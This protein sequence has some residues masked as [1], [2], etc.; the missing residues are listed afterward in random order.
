MRWFIATVKCM[1]ILTS[2]ALYFVIVF[3][4][5]FALGPIRVIWVEPWLGKTIAAL[6][7]APFLLL[8]MIASALWIPKKTKL[9]KD[10]M[11]LAMM[12]IGALVFQQIAD[13]AVGIGLRNM[14]PAEQFSYLITPAGIIYVALLVAFASMPALVNTRT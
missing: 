5:G 11:S 8:A 14:T 2:A 13:F 12:G 1:R 7:E 9:S 4:V 3:G 10:L 6:C